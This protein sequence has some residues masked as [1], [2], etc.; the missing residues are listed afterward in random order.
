MVVEASQNQCFIGKTKT[1]LHHYKLVSLIASSLAMLHEQNSMD[2]D[3]RNISISNCKKSDF[4][5]ILV[6]SSIKMI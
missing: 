6:A 3:W 4:D 1:A 5:F 2:A